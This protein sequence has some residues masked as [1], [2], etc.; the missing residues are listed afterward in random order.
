M[1]GL[2]W[3]LVSASEPKGCGQR[4]CLKDPSCQDPTAVRGK[5]GHISEEGGREPS[6]STLTPQPHVETALGYRQRRA[7]AA[8]VWATVLVSGAR[9]QRPRGTASWTEC[10][11]T[12]ERQNKLAKLL[13]VNGNNNNIIVTTSSGASI[14]LKD[15]EPFL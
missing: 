9:F 4:D 7:R 2:A 14:R 1:I 11:V 6:V 10:D 5:D 8:A 12:S 3:D 15:R 13:A